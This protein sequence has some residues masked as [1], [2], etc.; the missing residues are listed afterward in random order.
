MTFIEHPS[1]NAVHILDDWRA[2]SSCIVH[3]ASV[4]QIIN[5]IHRKAENEKY[6]SVA[7][8]VSNVTTQQTSR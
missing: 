3:H 8:S 5:F 1:H 6:R 2:V 7:N 4:K